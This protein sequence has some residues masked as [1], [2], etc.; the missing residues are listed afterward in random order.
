MPVNLTISLFS[1][2]DIPSSFSNDL[3]FHLSQGSSKGKKELSHSG[4]GVQGFFY[5]M[6]TN[7]LFIEQPSRFQSIDSASKHPVQLIDHYSINHF[8]TGHFYDPLGARSS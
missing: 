8:I 7:I 2:K 6:K 1:L 5:G 3:T 4:F